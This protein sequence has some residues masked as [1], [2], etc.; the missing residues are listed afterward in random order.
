M[1]GNT[2][3]TLKNKVCTKHGIIRFFPY[4][5]SLKHIKNNRTSTKGIR[6]ESFDEN[7]SRNLLA[8]KK[9]ELNKDA[10]VPMDQILRQ[11]RELIQFK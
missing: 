10:R 5:T 4:N 2:G 6:I 1:C 7:N 9:N 8:I 11:K 3:Y